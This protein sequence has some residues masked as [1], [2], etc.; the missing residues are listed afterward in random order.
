MMTSSAS[1]TPLTSTAKKRAF[2][3]VSFAADPQLQVG[4]VKSKCNLINH[5][6]GVISFLE[7]RERQVVEMIAGKIRPRVSLENWPDPS[8]KML[9]RWSTRHPSY[10]TYSKHYMASQ[11]RMLFLAEV[12]PPKRFEAFEAICF[13]RQLVPT[14]AESYWIT[15]LGVQ[16]ALGIIPSDADQRISKIMKA[17]ATAYPVQFPTP[18]SISDIDL[19]TTTFQAAL[20]SFTAIATASFILGQRISDLI[21]LAVADLHVTEEVLMITV[22]RGKTMMTTQPYTLWLRRNRYPT[23]AL[24]SI[25]KSAKTQG[26]LFLFSEF[27]L[28]EERQKVLQRIREML[29]SVNDQ[30]ELRSLRRGGLQRMASL[31]VKLETVLHF[32]RHSD[33]SMLLRYLNWGKHAKH[34]QQEM[35]EAI[36]SSTRDMNLTEMKLTE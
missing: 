20:P 27:N 18:A 7:L 8:E 1:V 11:R 2:H 15:W 16:K 4:K 26:R 32:S 36:D 30:L 19:M 28:D 12:D 14:T 6:S 29:T 17:R 10:Q 9:H 21:Q 25:M 35:L 31:E 24:I 33:V 5:Q 22:R 13:K 3:K 34:R 23:E